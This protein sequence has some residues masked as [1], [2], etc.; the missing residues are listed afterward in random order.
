MIKI[1]LFDIGGVVVSANHYKNH[2]MQLVEEAFGKVT[3][4]FDEIYFIFIKLENGEITEEKAIKELAEKLKKKPNSHARHIFSEA[5]NS[6]HL[7][8]KIMKIVKDIRKKGLKTGVLS[9]A[10]ESN[11]KRHKRLGH[12]MYFDYIILSH[13]VH[14]RKPDESIY[15]Y[16]LGITH[17][18]ATEILFI[19]D[20]L[21]NIVIAKKMKFNTIYFNNAAELERELKNYQVF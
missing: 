10:I 14:M 19:D 7:R 18:K 20:S 12:Y 9:N 3:L 2:F 4:S 11:A 6:L 15:N 8:P 5:A 1:V 17:V 21:E 16:A 13:E